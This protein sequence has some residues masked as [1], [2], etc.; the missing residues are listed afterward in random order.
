MHVEEPGVPAIAASA[1]VPGGT[2]TATDVLSVI[3]HVAPP[4]PPRQTTQPKVE[5]APNKPIAVSSG[6]QSAKLI[7][8]VIPLYPEIAKRARIS[9]TVRLV[10][11]VGKDGTIENLQ[12]VSGPPLLVQAALE[13]VRQ[14]IYRPTLLN[15]EPV[16]VIAPIDVIFTLSQ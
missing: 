11:I 5:P 1:G 15:G 10:G 3:E 4:P 14:W 8:R 13:A 12:L 6:V 9:G 16:E 2:G 7:R